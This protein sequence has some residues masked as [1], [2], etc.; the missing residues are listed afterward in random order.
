MPLIAGSD[1][2]L[3]RKENEPELSSTEDPQP[4]PA[5]VNVPAQVELAALFSAPGHLHGP[6]V[7]GQFEF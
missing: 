3:R 2:S 6:I 4:Q 5:L 1:K 7:G